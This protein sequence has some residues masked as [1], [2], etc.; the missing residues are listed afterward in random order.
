MICAFPNTSRAT[1]NTMIVTDTRQSNVRKTC[2]RA[3]L[4][5]WKSNVPHNLIVYL[6]PSVYNT[7]CAWATLSSMA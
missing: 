6:Q 5:Q 2:V 4:L 7:Q 3:I 1:R